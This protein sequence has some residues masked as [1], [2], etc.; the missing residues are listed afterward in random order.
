MS[1]HK[2]EVSNI[3]SRAE[4]MQNIILNTSIVWTFETAQTFQGGHV[5]MSQGKGSPPKGRSYTMNS[6]LALK[7]Q[8]EWSLLIILVKQTIGLEMEI[9]FQL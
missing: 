4:S 3:V 6:V 7:G 5:T 2:Q 8:L 1:P 9:P